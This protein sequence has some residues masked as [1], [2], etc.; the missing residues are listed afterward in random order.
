MFPSSE[1]SFTYLKM[2]VFPNVSVSSHV[3]A[4]IMTANVLLQTPWH[5]SHTRSATTVEQISKSVSLCKEK[6]GRAGQ[7]R[8]EQGAIVEGFIVS[9]IFC[10]SRMAACAYLGACREGDVVPPVGNRCCDDNSSNTTEE[11]RKEMEGRC[12]LSTAL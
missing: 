9:S 5:T 6:P 12:S 8:A 1:M 10:E 11:K 3:L 2:E 4:G 7:K